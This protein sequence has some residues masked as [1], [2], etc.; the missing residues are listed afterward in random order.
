MA[1]AAKGRLNY[2]CPS[3]FARDIDVDMFFDSGKEEYYCL[4]CQF[5]GTE[6]EV[7]RWNE[8]I[9]SRYKAMMRRF[10]DFESF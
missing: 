6:E 4:R 5:A 9:R 2:R 3:C 1:Q 8:A 10:E 7:L